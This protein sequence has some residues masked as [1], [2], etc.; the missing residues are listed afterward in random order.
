MGTYQIFYQSFILSHVELQN[1][2]DIKIY[3]NNVG[4]E[5]ILQCYKKSF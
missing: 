2:I 3:H 4:L 1:K 5:K